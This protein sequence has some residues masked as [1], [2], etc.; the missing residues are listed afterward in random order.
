[1]KTVLR[2]SAL[3]LLLAL[4]SLAPAQAVSDVGSCTN[5]CYD[6]YGSLTGVIVTQDDFDGCCGNQQAVC[7]PYYGHAHFS[8]RY[9]FFV[10][11]C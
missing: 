8:A 3:A 4:S 9:Y 2:I 7:G 11:D 5:Y 10:A 1:M 6:Q